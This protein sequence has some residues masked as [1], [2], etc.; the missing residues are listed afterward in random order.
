[1]RC[2]KQMWKWI[3]ILLT[4]VNMNMERTWQGYGARSCLRLVLNKLKEMNGLIFI[5]TPLGTYIKEAS[6][7]AFVCA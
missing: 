1:M 3:F 5:S 7:E 4:Y 6:K 2:A